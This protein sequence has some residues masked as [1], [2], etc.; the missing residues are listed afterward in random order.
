SRI[1]AKMFALKRLGQGVSS[2]CFNRQ[3]VDLQIRVDILN[4]FT[5]LGTAKT[6]AVA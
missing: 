5:Q 4:K 3:V 1:E 2:R 6:V